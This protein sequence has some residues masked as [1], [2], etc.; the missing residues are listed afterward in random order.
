MKVV[1]TNYSPKLSV[2]ALKEYARRKGYNKLYWYNIFGNKIPEPK[3]YYELRDALVFH[4]D[5]GKQID[6]NTVRDTMVRPLDTY[7]LDNELF[8]RTDPDLIY[9]LEN[10][11]NAVAKN[12]Y[13][14]MCGMVKIVEVPDDVDWYIDSDCGCE[15]VAEK[16]RTWR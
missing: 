15:F 5:N 14:S 1:I 6:W 9:V 2:P 7:P 12:R 10:V 3:S 11:P 16:H 8:F 4:T 13:R